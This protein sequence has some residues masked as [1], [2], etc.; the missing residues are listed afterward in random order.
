MKYQ[1]PKKKASM[2][3]TTVGVAAGAASSPAGGVWC[4]SHS[5]VSRR[6]TADAVAAAPTAGV[7]GSNSSNSSSRH[8]THT[9]RSTTEAVVASTGHGQGHRPVQRIGAITTPADDQGGSSE[10]ISQVC[11]SAA[12]GTSSTAPIA[13]NPAGPGLY[14]LSFLLEFPCSGMY[15]ICS[16]Y[17]YTYS[18]LQQ[19][20]AAALLRCNLRLAPGLDSPVVRSLLCYTLAGQ[21]CD[22]LTITDFTASPAELAARE[23]VVITARVHPG[24]TCASWIAQVRASKS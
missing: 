16:C 24:E 1:A 20:L 19:E 11:S 4:S 13:A 3:K 18:D 14:C 2:R 15:L 17:P 8:H 9:R 22:L 7:I 10:G 12:S 21:Q 6:Q 23:Y 5:R